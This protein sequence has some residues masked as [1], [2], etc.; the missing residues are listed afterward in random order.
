[1]QTISYAHI[2]YFFCDGKDKFVFREWYHINSAASE[3][4]K[5]KQKKTS[6]YN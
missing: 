2:F 6:D 5:E 1:M 3:N 4:K